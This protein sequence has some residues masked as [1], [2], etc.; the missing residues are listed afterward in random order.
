MSE[1]TPADHGTLHAQGMTRAERTLRMDGVHNVRDYGG[2]S[3]S[4]GRLRRNRLFRSGHHVNASDAD[5]LRIDALGLAAVIDL[6]G[7]AE[8]QAAPCRRGSGFSAR[9]VSADEETSGLAPHLHA[10]RQA[11]S[12]PMDLSAA[13]AAMIKAYRGMPF[14]PALQRLFTRY[15]QT[16][17][18]VSGPSLVHCAAGKDRTGLAVALLHLAL[19][20]HRDDVVHDYLLTNTAS[21]AER[22]RREGAE[23][24]RAMYGADVS[25]EVVAALMGVDT[26]YL[27]A[28]L[29]AIEAESGSLENYLVH[30]LSLDTAM[31]ERLIG[32]LVA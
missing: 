23:L 27:E 30:A 4:R 17:A 32:R 1:H 7:V 25:D 31:R 6:R 18:D 5:C 24:V 12:G 22:Q 10:A 13:Q 19:G 8:R 3:C 16:L 2:Y 20:V 21:G 14:R 9:V 26:C 28:A 15:F 29:Q 11:S